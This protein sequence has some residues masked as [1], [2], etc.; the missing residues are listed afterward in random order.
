MNAYEDY[1][2]VFGSEPRLVKA[3]AVL[4]DGDNTGSAVKADYEDFT[5]L[6]VLP[7]DTAVVAS[8]LEGR[9]ND[10]P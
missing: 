8:A 7:D 5:F 3:L 9:K 1:V 4:T 6:K 10:G 2:R